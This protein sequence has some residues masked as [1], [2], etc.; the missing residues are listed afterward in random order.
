MLENIMSIP[1]EWERLEQAGVSSMG[2]DFLQHMLVIEPTERANE[3]E[4]LGH[5]WIQ[6]VTPL[7]DAVME[8]DGLKYDDDPGLDASQL[9]L[10][11]RPE[12][13]DG[14]NDDLDDMDDPRQSKRFRGR[15]RPPSI[16]PDGT[17]RGPNGESNGEEAVSWGPNHPGWGFVEEP[18][19]R[20]ARPPDANN[21]LFGEISESALRSSGALGQ[22]ANAALHLA[23]KGQGDGDGSGYSNISSLDANYPAP[24]S[25]SAHPPPLHA[26][27]VTEDA[28]PQQYYH[29]PY[30]QPDPPPSAHTSSLFGAEALVDQLNM[31]SPKSGVSGP[32]MDSREAS[33]QASFSRD[34]SP[35]RSGS[36]RSSR[37]FQPARKA[38]TIKKPRT[39]GDPASAGSAGSVGSGASAPPSRDG[40]SRRRPSSRH[41]ERHAQSM[42]RMQS[43]AHDERAT[44]AESSS[45][46]R[47]SPH[48]SFSNA[49]R[50]HGAGKS[51]TQALPFT[52]NGQETEE[53]SLLQ[54]KDGLE[55]ISASNIGNATMGSNRAPNAAG[56]KSAIFRREQDRF[57]EPPFRFGNLVALPGSIPTVRIKIGKQVN[58]FGRDPDSTFPHP[59]L[60]ADR[61]PKNAL[62]VTMYYPGI[63]GD[64]A[65]G[66]TNWHLREDLTA[67]IST[68]T[69]RYI[70]VNGVRLMRGK[71]CW[72]YGK[73]HTGDII[74]IFEAPEGREPKNEAEKMFL[75]FRCEFFVGASKAPRS[76]DDPFVVM[77]AENPYGENGLR[78]SQEQLARSASGSN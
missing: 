40:D 21:R 60:K 53:L 71:D 1:V 44:T 10:A 76:E 6:Q 46:S 28:Y 39:R 62:D 33:D 34:V 54:L 15:S 56:S 58:S 36:K 8:G 59:D 69:T 52:F 20:N 70:K 25:L 22:N 2:I 30:R 4:Q 37:Q 17:L 57:K 73:L 68:R 77:K 26:R 18:Q 45:A 35:S 78:K 31:A 29:F 64:I 5:A 49:Q 51:S 24:A 43:R 48:D 66:S 9:S 72:L 11:D 14:G 3:E 74:S 65:S 67:I 75:K 63:E 41:R 47:K 50:L 27:H 19:S 38:S 42:N 61:V 13:D 23:V 16:N 32:S 12:K 7:A 55:P